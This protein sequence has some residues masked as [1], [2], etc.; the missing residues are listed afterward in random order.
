MSIEPF[1]VAFIIR[2]V[3]FDQIVNGTK[4][5]EVRRASLRWVE[6]AASVHSRLEKKSPVVATFLCGRLIHRREI[7]SVARFE[8]AREA[9]GREPSEQG[10]KDIGEG[11]VYEFKLGE[12]VL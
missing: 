12:A 1:K 3:Y 8:T 6:V 2:R 5:A 11:P 10:K 9:L 7:L 4:T